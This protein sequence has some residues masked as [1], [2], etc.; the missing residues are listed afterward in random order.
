MGSGGAGG[1]V[2][3]ARP[4]RPPVPYLGPAWAIPSGHFERHAARET[5]R[6]AAAPRSTVADEDRYLN[7]D[8]S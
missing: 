8:K 7:K 2:F 6:T 5:G 3:S 1:A 4:Y